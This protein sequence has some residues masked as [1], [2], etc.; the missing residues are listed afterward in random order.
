MNNAS[1]PLLELS[2]LNKSYPGVHAL[3]DFS[4][5]LNKGEL[6][7]LLG[8]NGA[9]KS[10]LIKLISGVEQP[11]SGA[12][13]LE[14]EKV[15]IN[16]PES[17]QK[18]GVF[19]I[20]QELSLIP[21]LSVAENIF[22]ESF[23]KNKLGV[24]NWNEM[25]RKASEIMSWLG[26]TLDVK[27]PIKSLSV[28]QK[29]CV[30]LGK[31]L[32]KNAKIILLDEP[33][34]ALPN[35][36]VER[37]FEILRNLSDQGISFI[38]ISHRLDEVLGLCEKAT[39]LRDGKKI[40]TMALEGLEENVLVKAMIGYDLQTSIMKSALEGKAVRLGSG[41]TSEVVMSAKN[42]GDGKSVEG[43]SFDLHKGEIL[44]I[45]GLVGSGQNELALML[46]DGA[47]LKE[48]SLTINDKPA[49][50]KSPRQAV[51]FG[52][53]LLP[54]ERKTQGL[55]LQQ[56]I[57][58]NISIANLKRFSKFWVMNGVLETKVVTSMAKKVKLK[59]SDNYTQPVQ[60]LSG[61]NQQKVVFSKW[62]VSNCKI[63]IFSE[64]TRGIDV[65]AK[66]DVYQLI[67]QYAEDGNS[68]II[69]TSE[70]SE[71]IM[72]DNVLI[73]HQGKT[74][75]TISHADIKSEDDIL[76]FYQ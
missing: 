25:N 9:G 28:A 7:G 44:G 53:G 21:E 63:L 19:T 48:G 3:A 60:A 23:P 36:E 6:H 57:K 47:C 40:D 24:I 8:Q 15:K 51:N 61:G 26:F 70:I 58:N 33:T 41:G 55:V 56:S 5:I 20:F 13:I 16:S 76:K 73:M 31:A 59:C 45:T 18:A 4:L 67:K 27:L 11:D 69:I 17:A 29:Q 32:H 35:H 62:L 54:E 2:N 39:I 71:A 22:V 34:A 75:G 72:C 14:G 65:G 50:I 46:F 37:F 30:E 49:R 38:F 12:I 52:L 64:P 1:K 10:T 68:V 74:K 42:L 66:E 43:I